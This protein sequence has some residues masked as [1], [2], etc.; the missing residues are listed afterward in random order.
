MSG[1]DFRFADLNV[2]YALPTNASYRFID[3]KC[4]PD[5]IQVCAQSVRALSADDQAGF[6]RK[7]LQATSEFH[8]HMTHYF[9][10][11][12]PMHPD[13]QNEFDKGLSQPLK[14]LTFAGV[15][16]ESRF[17]RSMLYR[18]ENPVVIDF[19]SQN[20]MNA[21]SFLVD[22]IKAV[23]V[24][25]NQMQYFQSYRQSRHTNDDLKA[26]ER[27]FFPFAV[28]ALKLGSR[29]G[30]Q[31][32]I[33]YGRI[34]PKII[35]PLAVY[36]AIP[37]RARGAVSSSTFTFADLMY[38]RPNW[39]DAGKAKNKPRASVAASDALKANYRRAEVARAKR[40]VLSFH[41]RTSE[42]N[43]SLNAGEATQS[44]HIFP[45]STFPGIAAVRENLIALTASQHYQRAHPGNKTS[46]IDEAYQRTCILSKIDSIELAL[47][48]GSAFYTVEGLVA[49][50]NS[51]FGWNLEGSNSIHAIREIV[52][53]K[54][55]L[56]AD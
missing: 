29:G 45:E 12:D 37:G 56:D 23:L 54:F 20:S 46:Q 40:D 14:L 51:G 44:H 28:R 5:I 30:G 41:G 17:G 9:G 27:N 13:V 52:R 26:L 15:L 49:V 18:V 6:T 48:E 3:Q 22:Y 36:W 25:N 32:L 43:D 11:P 38:N 55:G 39:R 19:V 10:K 35:N 53:S 24:D 2:S 21:Y 50:L 1:A 42:V 33:E 16:R 7:S 34:F 8:T 31:P 47:A 4:T